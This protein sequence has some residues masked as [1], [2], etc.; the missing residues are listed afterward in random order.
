M[1]RYPAY[2]DSGVSWL[3]E[4]PEQWRIVPLKFFVNL[5]RQVL[6]EGTASD[7]QLDYIDIGNVDEHGLIE[8][9]AR[10]K[11]GDAPSRARRVVQQGDTIISTVRTYLK[12]IA[13]ISESKENLIASTGFAVLSPKKDTDQRFL[14]YLVRGANFINRVTAESKGVNYP[15]V[16]PNEL[17]RFG[18]AV[19]ESCDEQSAIVTFLD[20]RLADIDRYIASKERQIALLKEQKTAIINRAVIS[21]IN[22]NVRLR[23]SGLACITEIP[24]HWAIQQNAVLFRERNQTGFPDLPIL[25][26]SLHTGVTVENFAG[27]HLK[28]LIEDRATYKRAVEGDIAYNMMRMWQGAVGVV[29]CDGLVSPAY[30]VAKPIGST[31][32]PYFA[33]LFRTEAYKT[34]INR[35]SHGIVTDR[36]RLYW[37]DFKQMKSPVPPPE[38]QRRIVAFIDEE[39]VKI[40]RAI[41]IAEREIDLIGEYRTAL[42]SEAVTGKIDVRDQS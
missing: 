27:E 7:F 2:K 20:R 21:G 6:P 13:F 29:P 14:A 25:M 12:A 5:N 24:L 16:T 22:P 10:M 11:F 32:S 39:S 28:R 18:I 40:E 37:D 4:I 34:A 35:E 42:I 36:N 26:V 38:E 1:K 9:P 19:P 30:V 3:G 15:A 41:A 23:P 31:Y 33:Y 8:A 17:G